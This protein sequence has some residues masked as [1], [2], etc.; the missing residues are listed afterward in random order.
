LIELVA[1]IHPEVHQ[2]FRLFLNRAEQGIKVMAEV[3]GKLQHI[4]VGDAFI[5]KCCSAS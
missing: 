1:E 3:V 4:E 2:T 5:R